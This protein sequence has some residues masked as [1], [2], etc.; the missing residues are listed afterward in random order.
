M[1]EFNSFYFLF[2]SSASAYKKVYPNK[3]NNSLVL[4]SWGCFLSF[5]LE[6]KMITL[7]EILKFDISYLQLK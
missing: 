7:R 6:Y 5:I 3:A 1:Q 2:S 4:L